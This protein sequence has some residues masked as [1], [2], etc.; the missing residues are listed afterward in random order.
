M[1]PCPECGASRTV[2]DRECTCGVLVHAEEIAE[3]ETRARIGRMAKDPAMERKALLRITQLAP[4]G[5]PRHDAARQ[6]LCDVPESTEASRRPDG[7]RPPGGGASGPPS[8]L[9]VVAG[10]GVVLWL[11]YAFLTR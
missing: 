9:M 4:E 8:G 7:D 11:V 10:L 3:L 6:A 2:F 5:H 1:T